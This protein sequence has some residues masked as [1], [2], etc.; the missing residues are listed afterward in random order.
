MRIRGISVAAASVCWLLA[1]M[2]GPPSLAA[3]ATHSA[4]DATSRAQEAGTARLSGTFGSVV[5]TD[6]ARP[7][8]AAPDGRP[9]DTW[10]RAAPL[11]LTV[12]PP[13]DAEASVSVTAVAVESGERVELPLVG[14]R[15][16]TGP[17]APGL[18]TIVATI[19]ADDERTTSY[20]WSLDVPD[21]PGSWETLIER[22][23]IDGRLVAT[24]GTVTGD[25]GR[26]CLT[27]FCQEVGYRPPASTLQPLAVSVGE[28]LRL[29][30]SDGSAIDRW[31]GSVEPQPGTVAETR[32]A[33][34]TFD[35][36]VARPVLA[37]L[38]PDV[39]GEWLLALRADY[40]RERGWQWY[41]FRLVAE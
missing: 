30:L 4:Q 2:T 9:L 20:A 26:G 34:A 15:W 36:P 23:A 19:V 22:P 37:G 16:V 41:L 32:F 14:R 33:E 8:T 10:M 7:A 35:E 5:G 18:H 13:L 24:S 21:R 40:D 38:E 11:E 25:R 12:D 6:P 31:Q 39:A 27:G 17:D 29:E 28:P 1:S 3:D